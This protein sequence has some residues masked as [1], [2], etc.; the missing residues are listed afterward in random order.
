MAAL[1]ISIARQLMFSVTKTPGA[2]T[3]SLIKYRIE[4]LRLAD[5]QV[6]DVQVPAATYLTLKR[7]EA[8]AGRKS[9][10]VLIPR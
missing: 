1:K 4:R 7:T 8:L 5:H 6:P 2:L 9:V 10:K 3:R